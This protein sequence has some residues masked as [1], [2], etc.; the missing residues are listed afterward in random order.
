MKIGE[1]SKITSVS[2]D[3]I[4]YYEQR[5]LL[6]QATR[7]QSGYRQYSTDDITRLKFIT[8][9]KEL[10][11]T[12]KEISQLLNIGAND[13]EQVQSIAKSKA[14]ELEDRITKLSRMR[15]V[16]VELSNKCEKSAANDPCPILKSLGDLS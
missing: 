4:R 5:E 11:F 13:C 7:T 3:T 9:A 12:L 15:D 16:L 6:P 1:L 8:Q 10:G 14:R 2:I